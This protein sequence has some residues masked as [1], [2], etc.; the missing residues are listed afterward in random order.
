M[1][2]DVLLTYYCFSFLKCVQNLVLTLFIRNFFCWCYG[3]LFGW[4]YAIAIWRTQSGGSNDTTKKR[5]KKNVCNK[6][7]A[8]SS[9][10]RRIK[11]HSVSKSCGILAH[12]EWME[13]KVRGWKRKGEPIWVNEKKKTT[14]G[15]IEIE[16]L[17]CESRMHLFVSR[18]RFHSSPH[19]SH[20]RLRFTRSHARSPKWANKSIRRKMCGFLHDYRDN[21]FGSIWNAQCLL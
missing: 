13:P 18:A 7:Y 21:D 16:C 1:R 20:T 12:V 11:N 10:N 8:L 5:E 4:I 15:S 2:E 19:S 6:R 14:S 3:I 9:T 17:L